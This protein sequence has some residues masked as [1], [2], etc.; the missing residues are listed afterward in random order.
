MA[1]KRVSREET[2]RFLKFQCGG[3]SPDEAVNNLNLK[4]G[5]ELLAIGIRMSWCG[6]FLNASRL[7]WHF[8][9][10]G[11]RARDF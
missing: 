7:L 11:G 3:R 8:S 1:G 5:L 2:S 10:A 9:D 6:R 4:I